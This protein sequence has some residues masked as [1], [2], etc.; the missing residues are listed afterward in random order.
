MPPRARLRRLPPHCGHRAPRQR[1]MVAIGIQPPDRVCRI[2]AA[3]YR[4]DSLAGS[5]RGLTRGDSPDGLQQMES[6]RP[7]QQPVPHS[8]QPTGRDRL[9][10]HSHGADNVLPQIPLRRHR[11][12]QLYRRLPQHILHGL[13]HIRLGR[14]ARYLHLHRLDRRFHRRT[15][16]RCGIPDEIMRICLKNELLALRL[17]CH[18][19]RRRR[20]RS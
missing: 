18:H 4:S 14:H 6:G 3:V 8:K 2:A 20:Y 16:Q 12:H 11:Q 19:P 10:R 17:G 9:P 1:G 5:R 13:R 7:L 15:G